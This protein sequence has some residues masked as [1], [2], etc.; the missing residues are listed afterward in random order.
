MLEGGSWDVLKHSKNFFFYIGRPVRGIYLN[1]LFIDLGFQQQWRKRTAESERIADV[2]RCRTKAFYIYIYI[3]FLFMF[4]LSSSKN[5]PLIFPSQKSNVLCAVKLMHRRVWIKFKFMNNMKSDQ[6]IAQIH[7]LGLE[8]FYCEKE[9]ERWK[10]PLPHL[11]N[12]PVNYLISYCDK[13]WMPLT[14][15]FL[16]VF[17]FVFSSIPILYLFSVIRSFHFP[18]LSFFNVIVWT[19]IV[20]FEWSFS[21][22]NEQQGL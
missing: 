11:C 10:R 17:P 15:L 2:P 12:W 4:P 19:V 7:K 18:H 1:N 5:C 9:K 22:C 14:I 6:M 8:L 13:L 20:L 3:V 21:K 16:T